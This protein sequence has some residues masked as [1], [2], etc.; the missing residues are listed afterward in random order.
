MWRAGVL[1]GEGR[2]VQVAGMASCQHAPSVS[3]YR[4]PCL[5]GV[6][7]ESQRELHKLGY[8]LVMGP[9]A[10]PRLTVFCSEFV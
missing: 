6:E 1:I 9:L 5:V 4:Y 2:V 7:T 8:G 3:M 10:L